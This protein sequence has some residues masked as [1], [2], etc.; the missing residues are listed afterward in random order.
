M[1][2]LVNPKGP[3]QEMSPAAPHWARLL[4]VKTKSRSEKSEL[5]VT[6]TYPFQRLLPHPNKQ[7]LDNVGISSWRKGP[8]KRPEFL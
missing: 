8:M 7:P 6:A 3:P 2:H 1:K 4:E 5:F